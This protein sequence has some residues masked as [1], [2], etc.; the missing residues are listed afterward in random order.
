MKKTLKFF[1]IIALALIIGFSITACKD[2]DPPPP[3][4]VLYGTWKVSWTPGWRTLTISENKVKLFDY[5]N[6]GYTIENLTWTALTNDGTLE[7]SGNKATY[8]SG[9][10]FTGK[11]IQNSSYELGYGS[12]GGIGSSFTRAIFLKDGD[13]NKFWLQGTSM[14]NEFTKQ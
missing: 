12:G 9:F 4:S 5:N 14:Y 13:E 8:P 6:N 7:N 3:Q 1:G 2:D 10:S 11:I